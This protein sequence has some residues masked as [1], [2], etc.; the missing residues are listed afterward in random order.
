MTQQSPAH[1]HYRAACEL[2]GWTAPREYRDSLAAF[3]AA[4]R[5]FTTAHPKRAHA[6]AQKGTDA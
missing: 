6:A 1:P 5:H 3:R 4:D 2:C